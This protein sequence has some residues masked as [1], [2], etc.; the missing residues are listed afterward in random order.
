MRA[1][2]HTNP[3]VLTTHQCNDE[4]P[5]QRCTEVST[6]SRTFKQPCYRVSLDDVMT[7]RAGDSDQGKIRSDLPTLEWSRHGEIRRVHL[8]FPF[9]DVSIVSPTLTIECREFVP[10][11]RDILS[12]TFVVKGEAMELVMP[13]YGCVSQNRT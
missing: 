2:S 5:C 4:T 13:P 11:A 8:R 6:T 9:D 3:R 1:Q 10:K 12:E 7:F